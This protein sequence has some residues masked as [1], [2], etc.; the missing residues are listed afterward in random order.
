M[1]KG[2]ISIILPVYN[3]DKYLE[4]CLNS[5]INQTYKNL[6]IISVNDGSTDASVEILE[7]YSSVD[8]RIKVINQENEGLS[9]ARNRGIDVALGE[10]L[11]FVDSDDYIHPEMYERLLKI[12]LGY[13]ADIAR[14]RG[15]GV[16]RID[17]REPTPEIPPVITVRN[18]LEALEIFYDGRFYGWQADNSHVVWNMLFRRSL[19]GSL[20]FIEIRGIAEDAIFT[21]QIIGKANKVVYT[22]ERLY[23]YLRREGSLCHPGLK[24]NPVTA[25]NNYKVIYSEHNNYFKQKGYEKI[26]IKSNQAACDC[27]IEVYFTTREKQIRKEALN[28]FYFYNK[29][30][31]QSSY[32][33]NKVK[34]RFSVFAGCP[35]LYK[36][37]LHIRN[38][39]VG[40][41]TKRTSET[42]TNTG[43]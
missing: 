34:I 30:L 10:Y 14:C 42:I 20:R 19:L 5:L 27:F 36:T 1:T 33:N 3:V 7:R 18:T 31:R 21:P 9:S 23:Y 29:E 41:S 26:I 16:D 25:L 11:A 8:N 32:T 22:D 40:F 39:C 4:N 15:R 35:A 6:E 28:C 12:L 43:V 13:D 2:M 38:K 17:Y 24:V 37:M